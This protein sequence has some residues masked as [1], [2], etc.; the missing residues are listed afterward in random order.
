[1]EYFDVLDSKGNK[2]GKIKLRKDVHRD[3]DWHKAVHIWILNGKRELLIQKRAPDKDTHP[4]EWDISSAGHIIAGGESLETAIK[5][6]KEE[7]GISLR[8]ND[9]EYLWL[10][11]HYSSH[12]NDLII[13]NEFNDV[14]LVNTDIDIKRMIVQKSEIADIKF[15]DYKE[16]ENSIKRKDKNFVMHDVEYERLFNLLDKRYA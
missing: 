12:K 15:M 7:L 9:F 13:N 4:N 14:Y 11:K 2:T 5:E 10:L 1:M 16:L 8:E 6:V 3:G